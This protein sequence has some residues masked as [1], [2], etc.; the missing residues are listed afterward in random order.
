MY[1]NFKKSLFPVIIK[2]LTVLIISGLFC[3]K[4]VSK[5][6]SDYAKYVDPLIGTGI[7]SAE[8]AM[9]FYPVAPAEL[10]YIIGSPIFERVTIY[11]DKSYYDA[12]KFIIK[13]ENNSS[14]NI[15]I[16]SVT[17][18][19]KEHKKSWFTHS[20]I[21]NGGILKFCMGPLPNKKWGSAPEDTP[22]SM[23]GYI[24]KK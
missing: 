20:E 2:Y 5:E 11:L 21:K 13:A 8:G 6:L 10:V 19:G 16:Q 7:Y 1:K 17:L 4:C 22:P 3:I 9:G 12:D 23:S 18:N 24:Y 14:D 15:Y